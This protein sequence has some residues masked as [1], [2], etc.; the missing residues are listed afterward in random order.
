LAIKHKRQNI[1]NVLLTNK[2]TS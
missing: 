1:F 2:Q